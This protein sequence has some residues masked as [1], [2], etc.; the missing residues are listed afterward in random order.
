LFYGV[1]VFLLIFLVGLGSGWAS[2]ASLQI[3]GVAW[4]DGSGAIPHSWERVS[5][6]HWVG[7]HKGEVW[8][9]ARTVVDE[10]SSLY[11]P[12]V[13]HEVDC[14]LGTNLVASFGHRDRFEE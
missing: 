8:F 5:R 9:R 2:V 11:L 6:L 7:G 4:G 12:S 3:E 1:R 14:Y 10:R 13:D